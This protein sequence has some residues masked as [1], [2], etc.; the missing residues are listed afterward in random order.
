MRGI[1]DI[2]LMQLADGELAP[3]ES[4]RLEAQVEADPEAAEKLAGIQEVGEVVRADLE[5]AADE[6]E[7]KLGR[8]WAEIEKRMELDATAQDIVIRSPDGSR[9]PAK[10]AAPASPGVWGRISKWIDTYRGHVLTGVLSAGAVAAIVLALRPSPTV[11]PNAPAPTVAVKNSA[12][13]PS[14]PQVIPVAQ[15]SPVEID[16]VEAPTG[17][18]T[19]FTYQSDDGEENTVIWVTPDD[20][21]EGL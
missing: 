5:I 19:V 9:G 12:P 20:T 6:A 21:T 4:A 14:Q 11:A 10:V 3:E 7:P 2:D 18:S 8:M 17:T 16:A 15:P 13:E 1:R